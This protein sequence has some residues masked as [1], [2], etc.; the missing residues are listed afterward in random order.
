MPNND[1]TVLPAEGRL[2]GLDYG[3]KRLGIAVSTPEQTIASPLENYTRRGDDADA[4]LI[5]QVA[6]EYCAVGIVVGLPV[7]MS[8]EE[9][10]QARRAREFGAFVQQ[11]TGL[12]VVF[13]DE[14][15]SS[16]KAEAHLLAAALSRKKRTVRRDKLAAAFLLQSYLDAEDR[17]AQPASLD[18]DEPE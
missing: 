16:K 9:G 12:P 17:H 3:E 1:K 10:K 4:R 5:T 6:E 2:L 13:W 15:F 14:R 11:V 8:G 18:A 7:H